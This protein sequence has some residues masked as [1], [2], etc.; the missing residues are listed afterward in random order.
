MSNINRLQRAQNR[1]AKLVFR[2]KKHDHASPFLRQLHWL[3]IE[4]R[5]TYKILTMTYKCIHKMAPSYLQNLLSLHQPGRHGLR[6]GNDPTLLS[7]PRSRTRF[8]DR[9]FSVSA[10]R[11][12]N[13]LPQAVRSS[14][15]LAIFQRSLKTFLFNIGFPAQLRKLSIRINVTFI[16]VRSK[17]NDYVD[18]H[19]KSELRRSI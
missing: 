15:S 18:Q 11:L 14:P 19:S 16:Q 8:G 9:S 13:N 10:P 4:K 17:L 7:V 2:A 12:W 1:A 3:P 5:I 6:S